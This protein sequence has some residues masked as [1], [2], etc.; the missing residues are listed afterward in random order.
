MRVLLFFSK[1]SCTNYGQQN[2]NEKFYRH[3]L[4]KF[5]LRWSTSSS[6]NPSDP[7]CIKL[8]SLAQRHAAHAGS[9]SNCLC[10]ASFCI[11]MFLLCVLLPC[12][13]WICWYALSLFLTCNSPSDSIFSCLTSTSEKINLTRVTEYL[14]LVCSPSAHQVSSYNLLVNQSTT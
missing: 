3:F 2:R 14:P 6:R 13:L 10:V 7:I 1:F 11:T 5:Y 4:T 12:T 8:F 9:V